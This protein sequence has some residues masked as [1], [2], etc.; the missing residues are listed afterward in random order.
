[1]RTSSSRRS[2]ERAAGFDAAAVATGHYTRVRVRRGDAP[3]P[4]AARRATATRI[5]RTFLFS[6]TQDQLAHALF[7][8]GHLTKPEVRAH[9]E[10]RGLLVADKPDSHEICFVPDGDAGGFVERRLGDADAAPARSSTAAAA[11][12]DGIAGCT[13]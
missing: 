11:S 6:L 12:S 7:P 3:L 13:G 5:S 2:L 9:A 10:R 4:A 1:M 8:V